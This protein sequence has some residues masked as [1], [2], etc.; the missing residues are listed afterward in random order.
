MKYKITKFGNGLHICLRKSDGFKEGKE[1]EIQRPNES[2]S[3][4][5]KQVRE[6]IREEIEKQKNY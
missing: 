1:I 3:L 5:E 6:I 2:K 4:T